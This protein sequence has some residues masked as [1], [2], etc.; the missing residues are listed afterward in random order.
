MHFKVHMLA[1]FDSDFDM[2]SPLAIPIIRILTS[3]QHFNIL[4]D[5]QTIKSCLRKIK[6]DWVSL[7]V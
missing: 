6:I 3:N 7:R 4:F 1:N 2:R 5:N